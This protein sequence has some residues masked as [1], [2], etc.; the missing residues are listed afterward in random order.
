VGEEMPRFNQCVLLY[1]SQAGQGSSEID[2]A[3]VVPP[4]SAS[5]HQL[6][7][8]Q[9]T[10][11]NDFQEACIN[12]ADADVLFLMG[13]DGTLHTAIQVIDKVERMPVIGLLPS[14]TC[15]DFARTLAIPL[16]LAEAARTIVN[17]QVADIDIAKINENWFMNFVGVGLIAEASEN[18][19]PELK[20]KF[21]KLSYFISAIQSFK[22]SAPISIYLEI[23]G[24]FYEEIAVMA[25]V[26]N[27]KSIG[28]YPIPL[29]SIDPTDGLLNVLLIQSSTIVAIRE[30][31]S[32]NKDDIV[33]DDLTNVTHYSGRH[34]AIRTEE[35]K[36]V[37]TDGEMYLETPITIEV[38]PKKIKFLIPQK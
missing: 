15:N 37:D 26:M 5:C 22:Q 23:D 17:G 18:I 21:G 12:A 9:T 4:L 10:S 6:T 2:L 29:A 34:I 31:L 38:H 11:S 30:W 27:G 25:L 36:K 28:T 16:T 3:Q 13:G 14:G 7:I 1:N 33:L 24:E 19:N 20:N 8:I 35:A 32:L